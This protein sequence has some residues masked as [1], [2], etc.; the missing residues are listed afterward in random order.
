MVAELEHTLNEYVKV[1]N[2]HIP[3]RNLGHISPV[4]ALKNWQQKHPELFKQKVY[5]HKGL[6]SKEVPSFIGAINPKQRGEIAS[7]HPI[8]A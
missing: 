8:N 5:N 3:P 4:Q 7:I 1:Y 2:H 6:D